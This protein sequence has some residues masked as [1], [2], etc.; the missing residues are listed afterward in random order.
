MCLFKRDIPESAS[1]R[2]IGSRTRCFWCLVVYTTHLNVD[3]FLIFDRAEDMCGVD[4]VPWIP[5]SL[6]VIID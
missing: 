3:S 1:F 2:K 4:L 6:G 5:W